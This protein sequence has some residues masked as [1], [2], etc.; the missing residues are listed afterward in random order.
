MLTVNPVVNIELNVL[1]EV[2]PV[3]P[4]KVNLVNRLTRSMTFHTLLA[5]IKEVKKFTIDTE[6]DFPSNKPILIQVQ[7]IDENCATSMVLLFEMAH[8]PQADEYGFRWIQKLLTTIMDPSNKVYTWDNVK[9]EL[10][11]FVQYNLFTTEVVQALNTYDVQ[12]YFKRWYNDRFPHNEGCVGK[13]TH[14]DSRYCQCKHRPYKYLDHKWSLQLAMAETFNEFFDKRFRKSRWSHGLDSRFDPDYSTT[15]AN[16][17]K[18]AAYRRRQF[19]RE[20]LIKYAAFDCLS[21]T[22]LAMVVENE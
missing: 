17:E 8:L 3:K 7:L 4:Y 14:A 10:F 19:R 21:T 6:G 18:T 11:G 1:P 2:Q 15:S 13:Y 12:Y 20:R 22:K 5:R 16:E 9:R